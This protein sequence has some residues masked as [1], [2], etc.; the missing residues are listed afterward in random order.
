MSRFCPDAVF[1]CLPTPMKVDGTQD[2]SILL[3]SVKTLKE[4]NLNC[5]VIIKS[6]IIPENIR[7]IENILPKFVYNPEFLREKQKTLLSLNL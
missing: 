5:L 2:I 6:T 4:L 3:D 1:I 7:L